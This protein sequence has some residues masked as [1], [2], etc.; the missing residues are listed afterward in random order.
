MTPLLSFADYGIPLWIGLT[1]VVLLL[2][3]DWAF[4]KS[5]KDLANW[6]AKLYER[7]LK[8]TG[9]LVSKAWKYH[10]VGSREP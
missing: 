3:G 8:K 4:W 5:Q 2:L 9:R 6:S 1:G 7:Y 10:R